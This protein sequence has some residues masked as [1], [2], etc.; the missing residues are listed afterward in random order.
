MCG[1]QV[2]KERKFTEIC[3]GIIDTEFQFHNLKN[4][5]SVRVEA[6]AKQ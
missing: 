3:F 6:V 5:A 4:P 1:G 2:V